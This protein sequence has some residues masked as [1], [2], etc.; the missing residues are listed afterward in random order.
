MK[1]RQHRD[2]LRNRKVLACG[3]EI[4]GSAHVIVAVVVVVVVAI[5]AIVAVVAGITSL[6]WKCY[7]RLG[8]KG[9]NTPRKGPRLTFWTDKD[10]ESA[11][12]ATFH[13][14]VHPS[15]TTDISFRDSVRITED[16]V[17]DGRASAQEIGDR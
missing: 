3:D 8:P 1:T 15:W 11:D 17:V 16:V 9:D 13:A 12:K 7:I 10:F 6:R 14:N 2:L 5:V 4:N